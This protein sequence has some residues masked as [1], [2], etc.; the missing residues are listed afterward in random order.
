LVA[1]PV[2]LAPA[3]VAK[4]PDEQALAVAADSGRAAAVV[5]LVAGARHPSRSL[6]IKFH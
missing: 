5:G 1:V 4:V 2:D 3:V 6:P